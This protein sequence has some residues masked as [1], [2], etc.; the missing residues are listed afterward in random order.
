MFSL[1][2]FINRLN[3]LLILVFST[4]HFIQHYVIYEIIM[5]PTLLIYYW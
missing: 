4:I 3:N 2:N 5:K 1:V